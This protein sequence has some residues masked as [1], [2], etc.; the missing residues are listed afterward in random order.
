MTP[1]QYDRWKDFSRRMVNITISPRK[2][3]PSRAD[4]L[5]NINFFFECRMDPGEEWRRVRDWDWTDASEEGKSRWPGFAMSV[6]SHMRDLDEVFI[7]NYWSISDSE[8]AYDR[9]RE[10]FCDPVSCCVRAGLD[11]AVA[12]SAGVAGFTA[13]DIRKMYPEGVPDWVKEF[14]KPGT[15][16]DLEPTQVEGIYLPVNERFDAR[17]FD[18]LP[19]A[20]GVWL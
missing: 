19:D 9:A 10:R 8:A 12:P 4:V 2:K 18:E 17:Q 7:P 14:F 16:H 6:S 13:D 3:K 5:E 15:V 11:I 20:E 1:E